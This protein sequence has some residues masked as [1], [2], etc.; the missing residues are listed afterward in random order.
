MDDLFRFPLTEIAQSAYPLADVSE[1][2]DAYTVTVEIPG[3][4]KDD[5]ELT[6]RDNT[7]SL[8]FSKEEQKKE[9][10]RT[11]RHMERSYG[12]FERHF[13]FATAVDPSKV[14]AKYTDGILEVTLP[15]TEE[16]R[17]RKIDVEIK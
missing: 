8:R 3:L 6:V 5:I 16:A 2:A 4:K 11:Y 9:E 15:K 14:K 13:P 12:T 7:L 17:P 1:T 10:G